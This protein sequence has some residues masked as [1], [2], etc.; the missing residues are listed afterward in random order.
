MYGKNKVHKISEVTRDTPD[1]YFLHCQTN[2]THPS[3]SLNGYPPKKVLWWKKQCQC[4][5]RSI[6]CQFWRIRRAMS[7]LSLALD[8][9]G[10]GMG[11]RKHTYAYI[12]T[13]ND[14]LLF[15]FE[16]TKNTTSGIPD[17]IRQSNRDGIIYGNSN[18]HTYN[19]QSQS[20]PLFF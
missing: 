3:F 11:R 7:S 16:H 19:K 15:T 4:L 10:M 12:S 6:W 17:Q 1:G 5:T 20:A 14:L 13:Y 9:M 8:H 2:P 18:I